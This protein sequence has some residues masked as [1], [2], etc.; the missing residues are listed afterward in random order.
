MYR[1]IKFQLVGLL[2]IVLTS[3]IVEEAVLRHYSI[4]KVDIKKE[5]TL[6]NELYKKINVELKASYY[7][8]EN[9]ATDLRFTIAN[10]SKYSLNFDTTS[11]EFNSKIFDYEIHHFAPKNLRLIQNG[12]DD[13]IIG[14]KSSNINRNK[15]D[16]NENIQDEILR[17]RLF[18]NIEDDKRILLFSGKLTQ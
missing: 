4:K 18:C 11:L 2:L 12:K 14:L 13:L 17:V 15:I 6:D 5:N 9:Y 3:C 10:N 7:C 1:H 16:N 8:Y